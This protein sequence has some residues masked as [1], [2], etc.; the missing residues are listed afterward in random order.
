MIFNHQS[1]SVGAE[2]SV[3]R[4]LTIANLVV[5]TFRNVEVHR[6]VSSDQI[7]AHTITPGTV[8][9]NTARAPL[10]NFSPLQV[11]IVWE[12]TSNQGNTGRSVSSFLVRDNFGKGNDFLMR[13]IGNII[14]L[15]VSSL[16]RR[17]D[18]L[19]RRS[20][21]VT[22]MGFTF[23]E[24]GGDSFIF[25]CFFKNQCHVSSMKK[26]LLKLIIH[27]Q[28]FPLKHMHS[29]FFILNPLLSF[30]INTS[31]TKRLEEKKIL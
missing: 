4:E 11:H 26:S 21:R 10:V 19:G 20:E 6:S 16:G 28:D 30:N 1:V 24:D 17:S 13:E 15:S 12:I 22:E 2:G 3:S 25:G 31:P 29:L 27:F 8:L 5:T 23:G 18:D 9:R 7:I 14:G